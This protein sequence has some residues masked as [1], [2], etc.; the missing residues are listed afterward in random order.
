MVKHLGWTLL[1]SA[2]EESDP[3]AS[4]DLSSVVLAR[5]FYAAYLIIGVILL[6][7]MLIALLSNTY[8]RTEV[9]D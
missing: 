5:I 6:V 9:R 8:Q 4:V 1:G 2:E 7:N 3:M